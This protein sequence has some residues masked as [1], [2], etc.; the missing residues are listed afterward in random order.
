MRAAE[1]IAYT[2]EP[3]RIGPNDL[4]ALQQ[5]VVDFPYFQAAHLLLSLGAKQWDAAI[6]QQTLKR[7]AVA[8]AN[9]GHFF[10][11][12]Q[13]LESQIR[14]R[15]AA[16]VEAPPAEQPPAMVAEA[17]N[18]QEQT[19]QELN[20][21]KAAELTAD[22]A[23]FSPVDT[24]APTEQMAAAEKAPEDILEKEI[25]KQVV[26]AFVEKEILKT[27][28]LHQPKKAEPESFVDW[29]NLLKKNNGQSYEQIQQQVSSEMAKQQSQRPKEEKTQPAK[30]AD[31]GQ[32]R[33]KQKAIID[34]IIEKNP[35]AI[36]A[37]ENQKF[38]NAEVKARESLL[39]SEHLVTETLARI[40]ALQGSVNKAIRAY[41][42]LSLKYPQKSAYFAT[43][44]E[45]LK[46]NQ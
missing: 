29:L 36:R 11:L 9:R 14:T 44:I 13:G 1:L 20:I 41:E 46:T 28:E 31:P 24:A 25:E 21:L 6:Y 12:V 10:N 38:F 18:T 43:L 40:Y 17:G 35:G 32:R 8:S 27:P 45:K 33:E 2:K 30:T 37:R 5:L 23:A 15:E 26:S 16:P 22:Q 7:T 39:E 4:A 19:T 3:H 34:S 42:I